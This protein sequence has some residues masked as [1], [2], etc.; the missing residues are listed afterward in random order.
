M[1]LVWGAHNIALTF[2]ENEVLVLTIEKARTFATFVQ[3][4]YWQ[5]AGEEGELALSEKDM[6]I[7][8]EDNVSMVWNP[9]LT[10]INEKKVINKLYQEMKRI[11][12]EEFCRE[13]GEISQGISQYLNELS[14]KIPYAISFNEGVDS[15]AIYKLYGVK[16]ENDEVDLLQKL[17]EYIK[18][19]SLLCNVKVV[20]FINLKAYLDDVQ[21]LELYKTAFYYKIG[22]LLIENDQKHCLECEKHFILDQDECLIEL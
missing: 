6:L 1:K 15:L 16:L 10:D 19:L 5:C 3:N 20:I 14:M 9:F 18:V 4:V 13:L 8:I 21:L 22:M 11:S 2:H 7:S 12:D 17:M